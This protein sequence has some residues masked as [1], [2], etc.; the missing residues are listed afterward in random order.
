MQLLFPGCQ[1][2]VHPY[3]RFIPVFSLLLMGFS[4]KLK[5]W[6]C[7]LTRKNTTNN[8][9]PFKIDSAEQKNS[10]NL[11]NPSQEPGQE[12]SKHWKTQTD[13]NA[14]NCTKWRKYFCTCLLNLIL[15]CGR[16]FLG[17]KVFLLWRSLLEYLELIRL[18][19][20]EELAQEQCY[21]ENPKVSALTAYP[22]PKTGKKTRITTGS[23]SACE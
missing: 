22:C 3:F 15:R 23:C 11:Q 7:W 20:P 4:L 17:S 8:W 6:G 12:F 5:S 14:Y 10:V 18:Q 13:T 16:Y 9:N 2:Q 21:Q 1:W 19:M